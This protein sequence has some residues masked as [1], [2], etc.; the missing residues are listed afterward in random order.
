M[1]K[2]EFWEL[3]VPWNLSPLFQKFSEPTEIAAAYTPHP[4]APLVLTST[5][6]TR[7]GKGPIIA[8]SSLETDLPSLSLSP[9]SSISSLV[10]VITAAW[11]WKSGVNSFSLICEVSKDEIPY[12]AICKQVLATV[13]GYRACNLHAEE[14]KSLIALGP[15]RMWKG[16]KWRQP[17]EHWFTV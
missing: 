10:G 2:V 7:L 6:N 15:Y 1:V 4:Q 9:D 11:D 5:S 8:H 16:Q 17:C 3:A 14:A 12:S 13:A